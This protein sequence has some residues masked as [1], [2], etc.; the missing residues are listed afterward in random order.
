[1]SI[2][3]RGFE[4]I[5]SSIVKNHGM[6]HAGYVAWIGQRRNA[7]R[8][9]VGGSERKEFTWKILAQTRRIMLKQVF[10]KNGIGGYRECSSSSG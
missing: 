5:K 3:D 6:R 2:T 9:L 10:K 1:M 4:N 8:V 7:R